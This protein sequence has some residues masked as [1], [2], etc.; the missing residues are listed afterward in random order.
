MGRAMKMTIAAAQI[1]A[2][3]V[4]ALVVRQNFTYRRALNARLASSQPSQFIAG[5]RLEQLQLA[6]LSGTALRLDLRRGRTVIAIVDPSCA[7]CEATIAEGRHTPYVKLI[8]VG[9]A[10]ANTVLAQSAG[11]P[12]YTIANG[13]APAAVARKLRKFPQI[14]LVDTGVVARTC[15]R[16]AECRP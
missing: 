5:E 14:L 12:V 6:D 4:F 10:A 13:P 16:L 15:A 7:S 9:S 2:I 1:A 3:V 8:S 11:G